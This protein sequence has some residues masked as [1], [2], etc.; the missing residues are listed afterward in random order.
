MER[1]KPRIYCC[2]FLF[3]I[4]TPQ[5]TGWLENAYKMLY[6]LPFHLFFFL[7]NPSWQRFL[8]SFRHDKGWV[9]LKLIKVQRWCGLGRQTACEYIL[10]QI[11]SA[12]CPCW[13]WCCSTQPLKSQRAARWGGK[14][15]AQR[16]KKERGGRQHEHCT[17]SDTQICF[18]GLCASKENLELKFFVSY[19][20]AKR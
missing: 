17:A 11:L 10:I 4:L 5:G 14:L 16:T 2:V 3:S 8:L 1:N 12:K 6:L 19:Y 9:C 15:E 13:P 20:Q 18:P 7:A